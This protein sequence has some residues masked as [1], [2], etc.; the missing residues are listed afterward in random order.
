LINRIPMLALVGACC[1]VGAGVGFLLRREF[2][3]EQITGVVRAIPIRK[4]LTPFLAAVVFLLVWLTAL[5]SP[6]PGLVH[7]VRTGV[8]LA[9]ALALMAAVVKRGQGQAFWAGF[10]ILGGAHEYL[11]S[12]GYQSWQ[13]IGSGLPAIMWLVAA[14]FGDPRNNPAAF[15]VGYSLLTVLFGVLGG[16]VCM[17]MQ[18]RQMRTTETLRD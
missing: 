8:V 3:T 10:A 16:F 12:A 4:F 11:L 6:T 17:W 14:L 7:A 5:Q 15:I 18:R 13:F 2:H 1:G 9:I